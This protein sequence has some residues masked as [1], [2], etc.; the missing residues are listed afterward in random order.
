MPSDGEPSQRETIRKRLAR[1]IAGGSEP[2]Q[3]ATPAPAATPS[4][5]RLRLKEFE[6]SSVRDVMTSRV[7]IAAA[8]VESTLGDVLSLF[9]TEAHSRMP[10]YRDSLDEPLG[11]VHIKDVV[12]EGVRCGWKP[13]TL[14]SRPLERLLRDI[15]FVPE[16][17]LL[18]DLLIQMQ[19]SRIHI[20]LVV[21]EYGGTGGMVCLEDLVEGI[22]GDIEDE[23]DEARPLI[24]RRGRSTWEID[25]LALI[26]DV[27]RETGLSLGVEDFESDVDTIGGLVA[28]I[29]GRMPQTGDSIE[30]PRGP[31]IEIAAADPRRIIR[32][33]LRAPK[34]QPPTLAEDKTA[35]I[36]R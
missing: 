35:A 12:A 14:A 19:A 36:D 1:L 13:E 23:H 30:H 32:L 26:A 24:I 25:G 7:D 18:P 29:A 17:T 16:S 4:A 10:V 9:A 33:R 31:T 21:D 6:T 11:F 28:A 5:I 3:P 20:A 34:P 2:K 27:E 8:D 15:M 22:V